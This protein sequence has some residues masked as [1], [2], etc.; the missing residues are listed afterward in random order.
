MGEKQKMGEINIMKTLKYCD[1]VYLI[2]LMSESAVL[3][4]KLIP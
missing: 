2:N 1:E 4:E 3:T